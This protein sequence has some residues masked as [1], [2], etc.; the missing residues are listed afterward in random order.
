MKSAMTSHITLS[1]TQDR[2]LVEHFHQYMNSLDQKLKKKILAKRKMFF[3]SLGL[4][5]NTLG[6]ILVDEE[7]SYSIT[8]AG[9]AQETSNLIKILT[10]SSVQTVTDAT[11]CVGGNAINFARQ[12]QNVNAFEI[13]E[14]R[15][16]YLWHNMNLLCRGRTISV[17]QADCTDTIAKH[18]T[19]QDLVFFDPPWGGEDYKQT[20]RDSLHLFLSGKDIATVCVEWI[21][22]TRYIAL[23]VPYNFAFTAFFNDTKKYMRKMHA[24]PMGESR[25]GLPK[26][27]FVLLQRVGE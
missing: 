20:G 25:D 9:L 8:E 13:D 16:K 2:E 24:Q 11:A 27:V 5:N 3:A 6:K 22:Y 19:L 23:K 21:P 17:Y 1:V 18:L 4:H 15:A 12:F 10:R 7:A 14:T 26:F